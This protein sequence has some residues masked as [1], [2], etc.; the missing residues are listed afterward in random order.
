MERGGGKK[1][2]EEIITRYLPRRYGHNHQNQGAFYQFHLSN[3]ELSLKNDWAWVA[4]L[5]E[6]LLTSHSIDCLG[7]AQLC[8]LPEYLTVW[9]TR[10]VIGIFLSEQLQ[11]QFGMIFDWRH[12]SHWRK[13]TWTRLLVYCNINFECVQRYIILSVQIKTTTIKNSKFVN[14]FFYSRIHSITTINS[15]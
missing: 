2:D 10:K 7:G 13:K 8:N 1:C 15:K 11:E 9:G 12:H 14:H 6:E 4:K 5:V 3:F